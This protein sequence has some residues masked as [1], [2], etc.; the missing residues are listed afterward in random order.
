MKKFLSITLAITTVAWLVGTF[1]VPT[2]KAA[3][4]EGDIVSPDAT[5]T[6]ADGNTYYPYDV[7]IVKFVGTKTF[8]RLV[9]NPQVFDSY[10]HLKWSNI[11]TISAATVAGYT[12]S[13]LVREINDTKV[14]KLSPNGDT[15]TKQWVE[16]LDC[17]NSKGY[18]WDSVY[19][20]NATDRDNYTTGASI[21]GGGGAAEGPITLSLASDNPAGATIPP[22]AQGVTYLKLKLDGSGTLNQV[23]VTRKGAGAVTDFGDI[24]IYKDGVRIGS[25]RALSSATSKVTFINLGIAA[26]ATVEVVADMIT[27]NAQVGDVNYFAIESASEVTGTGTVGG[28]YP[29]NGNPMAVSGTAAGTLTITASGSGSNN[30]T[31]GG[32]DQE[33][34]QFKIA[35]T[36]EGAYLKRLRLFNNGTADNE[37]ITNL[38]LKDNATASTLATATSI[39]S[40]GYLDFVLSSPYYIKKGESQ[41]F[42]VYADIGATKPTYTIKLYFELATDVLA[43]GNIYGYGMEADISGFDSAGTT[44]TEGIDITCIGGDLTLNKV[45]PNAGKIG[46]TTSDTVFLEYTMSAA[47]DITIKRT[48]LIFCEDEDG[49]GTYYDWSLAASTSAGA[50]IEDIKI[51]DKDSGVTIAGPKDGIAFND[52]GDGSG[53]IGYQACPGSKNG[54]GEAYTD[55]IDLT[56]GTT[57]TFQITAD[58]KTSNTNSGAI[59][60]AGSRLKFILYSYA[61]LVG[62]NG[63]VNYMKYAGTSDAV[64]DSAIVPSGDIAGEEMTVEAASLALSLAATPS[65]TTE[66]YIKGQAGVEAVGIIF[67]AGSASDVKVNSIT[68]VSAIKEATAGTWAEGIDTNYVKDS[69]GNVYI[70]DKDT[71]ALVPGSTVKG[72]SGTYFENVVYTGLNWT[73][74][75]GESKTL[76]VKGD[77]SSAAPA[78]DSS[79][80]TWIAFDIDDVEDVSAVDGDGNAITL[81]SADKNN[82]DG[83]SPTTYFGIAERGSLAIVAATDTP[84]KNLAIMGTADNEVSKFKLTGTN[85]GWNIEKFSVLLNDGQES[86]EADATNAHSENFTAVKLKYQ[87]QSQWGTSNWTISSGKT[88]GSTASLA[89]S[90]SGTNRIY[91]PKDDNAYVTALVSIDTYDGGNGA[92]SKI[93]FKLITISGSADSF[94]AYGAQSG[95]YLTTFTEPADTGFNLQFTARSKPVFA[96]EAWSGGELEL[97]RFSITAVGYDVVFDGTD[98]T[99]FAGQISSAALQFDVVASSTDNATIDLTLYDWNENILSSRSAYQ[100]VSGDGFDGSTASISFLFEVKSATIPSGTTKTFHVD[101][102]GG[103]LSDFSRTDEYIYLQLKNDDG[104]NLATGSSSNTDIG[105]VS[106]KSFDTS[107]YNVVWYDGTLDEGITN[108]P[109]EKRIGMPALIKNIGPLPITFR[110]LRGTL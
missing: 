37:K 93:P 86:G 85:E 57:R 18:D 17:F 100:D 74:P 49:D 78:S 69:I 59:I 31:I 82:I 61:S 89:F 10:G 2:A 30:V 99:P 1:Y 54:V 44:A 19:I 60:T 65:G 51:K 26:P 98:D 72:F 14:Y 23:T 75:A 90:F 106:T 64:D 6:D 102:G 45:G 81:A 34:S 32:L 68:L 101:I 108:W 16:T 20:I 62:A 76:L 84:D 79:A 92:R 24:Y 46:T 7:F 38:K 70:Y 63:T 104:G 5:F 47:A 48:G 110:T 103:D 11:K 96:K 66:T 105:E 4:V 83:G 91:V 107:A 36:S 3:V 8:K 27:T 21:C 22:N 87:T 56:A 39:S 25:G 42:R 15:G 55:T 77:I 52:E 97:A 94:V 50:D 13:S 43:T 71:G 40:A 73:I 95:Y 58:I 41:I 33:I 29:I 88:F 12:T 9:L 80:D 67:T 35:A 28:V 109:T 53:E